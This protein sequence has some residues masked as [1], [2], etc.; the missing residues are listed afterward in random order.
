M[1]QGRKGKL[2][3]YRQTKDM[4]KRIMESVPDTRDNDILL[5]I[6]YFQGKYHST[7]LR[8]IKDMVKGNE[9]E[10]VSRCRRKI[11]AENPFLDRGKTIKDLRS[12]NEEVYREEFSSCRLL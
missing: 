8:V 3:R 12:Q 5:Y 2:S 7:D 11:Q 1:E 4:V 9:F 10:T 6:F